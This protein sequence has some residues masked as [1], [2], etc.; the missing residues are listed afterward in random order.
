MQKKKKK[1]RNLSCFTDIS[2][3]IR[4][5]ELSLL[6]KKYLPLAVNVLTDNLQILHITKRDFVQLYCPY[7]D[8]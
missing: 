1:L 4:C 7:S 8:Q 5:V 2:I 3:S 6:T